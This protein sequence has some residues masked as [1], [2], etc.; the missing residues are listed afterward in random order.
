[1]DVEAIVF[2]LW[3]IGART[4]AIL[5]DNLTVLLVIAIGVAAVDAQIAIAEVQLELSVKS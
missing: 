5:V 2:G 1:M 4:L 3:S